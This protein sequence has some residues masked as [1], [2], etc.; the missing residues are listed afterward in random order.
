MEEAEIAIN[1]PLIERLNKYSFINHYKPLTKKVG[2]KRNKINKDV[3]VNKAKNK[4][5]ASC[6]IKKSK[7]EGNEKLSKQE[8][9]K[10]KRICT[11]STV[12]NDD[13]ISII[14]EDLNWNKDFNL[15][16]LL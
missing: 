15:E 9:K 1:L 6:R 13:D 5:E 14:L 8:R 3:D 11:I 7:I 16:D 12:S 10:F 4:K 2:Q